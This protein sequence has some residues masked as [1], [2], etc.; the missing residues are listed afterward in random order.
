MHESSER[1]R[2]LLA[3]KPMSADSLAR[4][5]GLDKQSLDKTLH[6]LI[7]A[8]VASRE[9]DGCLI[10]RR[11]VREE[12]NRRAAADFGKQ[13]G[14]PVLTKN[15]HRPG[16]VYAVMRKSDRAI[17]IGITENPRKRLYKLRQQYK[18]EELEML[19]FQKVTDMGR[20]KEQLLERLTVKDKHEWIKLK[21]RDR[22][23]LGL[24]LGL[25]LKGKPKG[26]PNPSYTE[27]DSEVLSSSKRR[28]QDRP[29]AKLSGGV[30]KFSKEIRLKYA[31]AKKGIE[32]PVRFAQWLE[33]GDQDNEIETWL[34]AAPKPEALSPQAKLEREYLEKILFLQTNS[35]NDYSAEDLFADLRYYFEHQKK[36]DEDLAKR[37]LKLSEK[38]AEPE[39]K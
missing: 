17:K 9:P 11:M 39:G 21:G 2:L 35:G 12:R 28:R 34:E 22:L 25:P 5:L 18:A 37:M 7:E 29:A 13:G 36:W 15:Y 23:T 16:F 38:A 1:G 26:R 30:S 20:A 19:G 4:L 14:N 3:G 8:G 32:D 24:T 6:T 31:F 33:N 10:N 27:T